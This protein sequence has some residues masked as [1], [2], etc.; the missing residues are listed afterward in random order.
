MHGWLWEAFG[1]VVGEKKGTAAVGSVAI[2][3]SA[4]AWRRR[5][6]VGDPVIR[7]PLLTQATEPALVAWAV[8][9]A[10]QAKQAV[11]QLAAVVGKEG[12]QEVARQRQAAILKLVE[13]RAMEKW[14]CGEH[15]KATPA[16][17]AGWCENPGLTKK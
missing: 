1:G 12:R 6:V 17:G 14:G 3:L 5:A 8:G 10:G 16:A 15:D 9:E 7:L 13:L 2:Q 4:A 11:G